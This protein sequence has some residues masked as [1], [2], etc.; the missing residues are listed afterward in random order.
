MPINIQQHLEEDISTLHELLI[1]NDPLPPRHVRAIAS[2]II[3]KWLFENHLNIFAK[4]I[5]CEITLPSYDSS[6][7][8][9]NIEKEDINFF[10]TGG[11]YL[12]GEFIRS[13]YF[14]SK[15]WQGK[16]KIQNLETE[17]KFYKPSRLLKQRKIFYKK[18]SFSVEQIIKFYCNKDGGVHLDF[19]RNE[20]WQESLAEAA[21]Y[22][23]MGNPY[24]TDEL[25]IVDLNDD[26]NG[27]KLLVLPKEKKYIW[28][29]LD[30]EM[31]GLAQSLVNIH[32]NGVRVLQSK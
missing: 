15:E 19:K 31:L 24:D 17:I 8:F 26:K 12:G 18:Q 20:P 4:N 2:P 6:S 5:E 25:K 28:N 32:C 22:F 13:I 27:R 10:I 16:P 29:A 14:S 3:R 11:I 9:E 7:I 30:V 1:R 23:I 21:E